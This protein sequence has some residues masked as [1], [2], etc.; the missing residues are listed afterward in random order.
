MVLS[1]LS[2]FCIFSI[3]APYLHVA[4]TNNSLKL[5][6]L[7]AINPRR[8]ARVLFFVRKHCRIS[9]N[10]VQKIKAQKKLRL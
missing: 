5:L 10:A 6:I 9:S 2:P 4:A 7:D 3:N 8:S 1:I